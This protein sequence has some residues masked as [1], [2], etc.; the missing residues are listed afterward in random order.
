MV[1]ELWESDGRVMDVWRIEY[2][3]RLLTER[4]THHYNG[5]KEEEKRTGKLLDSLVIN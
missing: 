2:M 1:E 4:L 5:N 3:K